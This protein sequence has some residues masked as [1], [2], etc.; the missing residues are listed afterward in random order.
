M[1]EVSSVSSILPGSLVSCLV[2]TAN[3]VGV[4]VR[5]MGFFDGTIEQQHFERSA[6]P[7]IGAKV[8]A[9]I[10]YDLAASPPRFALSLLDHIVRRDI[11]RAKNGDDTKL[12]E[13]YS[14]GTILEEVKVES[15]EAERGLFV[16]CEDGLSAFVH[17]RIHCCHVRYR[18]MLTLA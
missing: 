12:M 4:N 1:T 5:I 11:R 3:A 8:K 17:V 15:I 16:Q 18:K 2:T 14:A 10:L 9:R 13:K 7:K 6:E